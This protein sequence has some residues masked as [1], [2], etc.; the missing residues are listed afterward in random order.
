MMKYSWVWTVL[1]GRVHH[2]NF[3]LLVKSGVKVNLQCCILGQRE[4]FSSSWGEQSGG[5]AVKR[6]GLSDQTMEW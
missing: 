3:Y 1:I 4:L 2:K 6:Q 5:E